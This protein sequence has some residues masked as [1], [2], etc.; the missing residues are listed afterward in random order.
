MC[1]YK[2]KN[3]LDINRMYFSCILITQFLNLLYSW[4]QR[5]PLQT[6]K[7]DDFIGYIF[8]PSIELLYERE[9]PYKIKK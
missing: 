2:N 6:S 5:K 9:I 1:K 8:I 3:I 4:S 7:R